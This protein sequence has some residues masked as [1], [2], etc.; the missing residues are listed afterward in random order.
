MGKRRRE[1]GRR[2][3]ERKGE[4]RELEKGGG[5]RRTGEGE[6]DYMEGGKGREKRHT[7]CRDIILC[8]CSLRLEGT[9]HRIGLYPL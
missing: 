5:E 2:E 6:R 4:E 7:I 8:L 1:R 3:K 9:W